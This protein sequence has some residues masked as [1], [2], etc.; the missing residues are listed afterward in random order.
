MPTLERDNTSLLL[1]SDGRLVLIDCAGS[2][3]AKLR[4]LGFD[5]RAVTTILLTHVH[6]DHVYGLPSFIHSLMLEDGEIRL[7]GSDEAVAFARRLLDLFELRDKKVRTRVRFLAV[8]P[9]RVVRLA[10]GLCLRAFRVPHHVSSLAYHFYLEKENKEVLVSGDTPI[11]R[12]LFDDARG[13][14]CLV[15]EASAPARYFQRYPKLFGIHTSALDL[16]RWGR[17]AGVERLVPC[18]FLAHVWRAPDEI[19]AEIRRAFRGR[20]T[21]PRDLQC[22]PL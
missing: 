5:P 13:I 4:K 10:D 16:G 15:H 14:D 7:L 9:G 18:H 12:P 19:R 11:F 2:A 20:L 17:E 6:P 1:R 21:V 8:R 3:V 22:L